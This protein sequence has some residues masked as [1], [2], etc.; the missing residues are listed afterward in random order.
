M[1]AENTV[2]DVTDANFEAEVLQASRTQPVVVDFWAPWCGPCR[3]LGP[4]IEQLAG[5]YQGRVKVVKLNTDENPRAAMSF[6]I[7]SIPA[8]KAFGDGKVI[9]EFIG[10][11]PEPNVRAFFEQLLPPQQSAHVQRG[12]MALQAGQIDIAEREYRA[13]LDEKSDEVDAIVGLATILHARG[14]DSEAETLI[15]RV[16]RS[17]KVKGL[18]HRW[19]LNEFAAKHADEDLEGDARSAAS[20]PRARY[21]WGLMLA[22]RGDYQRALDELLESVRLDREFAEAAARKAMLAVFDIIGPEAPLSRDYQRRLSRL[23]F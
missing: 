20:D 18:K 21:R 3:V 1:S 2:I 12:N 17:R 23:L 19:F 16:P 5:E 14:E 11:Q 15:A 7:Q 13:A 8:V 4:V 9:A 6:Q 10:A 22:A